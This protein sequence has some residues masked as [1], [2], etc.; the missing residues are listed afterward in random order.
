MN[1]F[2]WADLVDFTALRPPVWEATHRL[3]SGM[4]LPAELVPVAEQITGHAGPWRPEG[5]KRVHVVAGR[6]SG[7]TDN[8][9]AII[10]HSSVLKD[11]SGTLRKG[12]TVWTGFAAQNREIGAL[13]FEAALA[14]LKQTEDALHRK[15][16]EQQNFTKDTGVI[17]LRGTGTGI[18]VIA[19]DPDSGRGP[20]WGDFV[21]EE[22][23]AGA[24]GDDAARSVG[25]FVQSI[26]PRVAGTTWLI[27]TPSGQLA[28]PL[29]RSFQRDRH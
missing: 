16:I 12:R 27:G 26:S 10:V 7:K 29:Y 6:G 21:V 9:A 2:E 18:R 24:V 28:G 3:A 15:L 14:L 4:P 22:A 20:Q 13:A 25:R 17:T 19:R 8:G 5:Y 11:W 1:I 23:G